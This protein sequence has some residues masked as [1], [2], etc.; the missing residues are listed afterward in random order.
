MCS[1]LLAELGEFSEECFPLALRKV[2]DR[3]E[4]SERARPLRIGGRVERRHRA[5]VVRAQEDCARGTGR[6]ED[7]A[8]VV[9]PRLERGKLAAEVGETRPPLVEQDQ[10]ERTGQPFEELPP[11]RRLPAVHEVR[12][13]VRDV[14]QIGRAVAD[15]LV[16]DRDA[17]PFRVAD[18]RVY[19]TGFLD[20]R[21]GGNGR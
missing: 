19:R 16:R 1:P 5:A 12:E 6:V 17:A 9:H 11:V 14:D 13:V 8:D 2:H 3:V 20:L 15:D 21:R 4:E 18:V 10:A 7:G